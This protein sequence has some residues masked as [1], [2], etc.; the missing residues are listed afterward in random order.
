MSFSRQA[1]VKDVLLQSFFF[2]LVHLLRAFK[3]KMR[4]RRFQNELLIK[5]T[6][7]LKYEIRKL[8][9][10]CSTS[11]RTFLKRRTP[12]RLDMLKLHVA[13]PTF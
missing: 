8:S 10:A 3:E 13:R 9:V 7:L 2:N 11:K 12:D 1:H 4:R 5:A 6:C